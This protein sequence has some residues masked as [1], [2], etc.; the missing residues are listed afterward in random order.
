MNLLSSSS[1][2]HK[3]VVLLEQIQ[4]LP[5]RLSTVPAA[6]ASVADPYI[7]RILASAIIAIVLGLTVA[8]IGLLEYAFVF[9]IVG[10]IKRSHAYN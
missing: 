1:E 10:V 9:L 8:W 6:T 2:Y 3:M 5:L 7:R 4:T